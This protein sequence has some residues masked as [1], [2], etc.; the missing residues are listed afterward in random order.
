M[1]RVYIRVRHG[2][3]AKRLAE[4]RVP[5]GSLTVSRDSGRI[6]MREFGLS[7]SLEQDFFLGGLAVARAIKREGGRF[8]QDQQGRLLCE[9]GGVTVTIRTLEELRMM[10]ETFVDGVYNIVTEGPV[11]VWDIGMN[12]GL[13]SLYFATREH[14]RVIGY[15]PIRRTYELALE[16]LALNPALRDRIVPVHLGVGGS[17]RTESVLCCDELR[18]SV[19]IRG[20]VNDPVL[21]RLLFGVSNMT[22]TFWHEEMV[23]QDATRIL[24]AIRAEH[25]S[26]PVIAKIDCEGAEYEIIESL[27]RSGQLPQLHA[28]L[29]EWHRD[30]PA[31]LIGRLTNAGFTVVAPGPRADLWGMVYAIRGPEARSLSL[32]DA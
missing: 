22:T 32:S 28:V 17:D 3:W 13:V 18:G 2:G 9:I 7:L 8:R 4:A 10:S 5:L 25:P 26:L 15:E 30:G 16:N 29:I 14:V 11:I 20:V 24:T 23:L 19:G 6:T 12:V 1:A 21:R 31:P 27:H